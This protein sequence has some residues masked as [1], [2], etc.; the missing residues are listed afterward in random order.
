M[1]RCLRAALGALLFAVAASATAMSQAAHDYVLRI[2]ENG[3]AGALPYAVVDKRSAELHVY[4]AHGR[5]AG[6]TPVLLGSTFGDHIVPGVGERAQRGAVRADER[7]TPAG[8]F[9]AFAGR[10][11][12]GERV[13]WVD[14]ESAFAI[15]R[16]RPGRSFKTRVGRLALPGAEGKRV[17]EGCVVVPAAFYDAVVLPVL[18]HGRSI[19]YVMPEA[20]QDL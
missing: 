5:L 2:K 11:N 12:T 18:G 19:V 17:S 7:T 14:Y 20:Q 15:H 3:D 1:Y 9:K 13:V 4:D 16:L 8:R 10:N 6:S